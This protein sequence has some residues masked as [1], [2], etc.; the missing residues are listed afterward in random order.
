MTIVYT[1]SIEEYPFNGL[2]YTLTLSVGKPS[3]QTQTKTTVLSTVCDIQENGMKSTVATKAGYAVYFPLS[4]SAGA[5][6]GLVDNGLF[7]ECSSYYGKQIN[8]K[9]IG[10]Y[11]SEL[12]GA[13]AYFVDIDT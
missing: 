8:G 11:G 13:V 1:D 4:G 6:T 10:V 9:V 2:F 3:T 7:F 5:Y 12:G